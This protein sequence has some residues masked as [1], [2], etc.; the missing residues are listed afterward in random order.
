MV[1]EDFYLRGSLKNMF[2][3]FR[4]EDDGVIYFYYPTE[5]LAKPNDIE[6]VRMGIAQ[7][8]KK[9]DVAMSRV[10]CWGLV[11]WINPVPSIRGKKSRPVVTFRWDVHTPLLST[12]T[13]NSRKHEIVGGRAV[14]PVLDWE[15]WPGLAYFWTGL[16]KGDNMGVNFSHLSRYPGIVREMKSVIR[17]EEQLFDNAHILENMNSVI[18]VGTPS[19]IAALENF[20]L[21]SQGR[22]TKKALE[23]FLQ[24]LD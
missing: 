14:H 22:L 6:P 9:Y 10:H 23:K 21:D 5:H 16:R 2:V 4:M 18:L 17:N 8:D 7:L 11:I 15:W 1:R 24:M 12:S 13:N 3:I 19:D 20:L